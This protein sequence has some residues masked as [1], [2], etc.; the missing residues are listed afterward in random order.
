MSDKKVEDLLRSMSRKSLVR[1]ILYFSQDLEPKLALEMCYSTFWGLGF[2]F[3]VDFMGLATDGKLTDAEIVS[4]DQ[5]P[6]I[7]MNVPH[8]F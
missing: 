4:W 8:Q 3:P 7:E 5:M 1:T 6:V 2:P